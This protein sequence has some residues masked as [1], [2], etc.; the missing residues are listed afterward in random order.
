[1]FLPSSVLFLTSSWRR[2]AWGP[3]AISC[4]PL[5]VSL[6]MKPEAIVVS[7]IPGL[8]MTVTLCPSIILVS[9]VHSF[10][11][12]LNTLL[13]R[14]VFPVAL[15]STPVLSTRTKRNGDEPVRLLV[16]FSVNFFISGFNLKAQALW[17]WISSFQVQTRK[18]MLRVNVIKK[19]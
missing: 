12:D 9:A 6:S 13:P 3:G 18:L 17:W 14:M 16:M 11:T 1:M 15:L 8:S 4:K 7:C 19:C 5:T 2:N 10:V